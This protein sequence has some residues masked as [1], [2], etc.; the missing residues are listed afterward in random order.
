MEA[1]STR[2]AIVDDHL[3]FAESLARLLGD[4]G[5]IVVAGI[6][7]SGARARSLFAEESP[8]VALVDYHLPDGDGVSLAR[9]LLVAQP[10]LGVII[11]TG[12]DDDQLMLAAIQ[13]GCA[14]FLTKDKAALEVADAVRTVAGG[15]ALISAPMLAR[16]LARVDR[17][18]QPPGS[19]LTTR[20]R[21]L[22]EEMARGLTNR[23][24]AE[25]LHLSV[26]TVRNYTQSILS[27]FGAH[28]KLEAVSLAVRYGL[29]SYP[30]D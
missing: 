21:D 9:D 29:I 13:A 8:H 17:S 12:T 3:M 18:P 7:S 6:A 28:S 2:V 22:L 25:E 26:N 10:D 1:E 20:E 14:G 19:D 4:E 5:D 23:A 27:K 30:K 16:L 11:L 15:E 24:I